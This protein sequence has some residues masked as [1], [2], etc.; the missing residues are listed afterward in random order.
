MTTKITQTYRIKNPTWK[1]TVDGFGRKKIECYSGEKLVGKI[2]YHPENIS[3]PW[4]V[5][6]PGPNEWENFF[7]STEEEAKEFV[8]ERHQL[9]KIS[10]FTK[11][12][13]TGIPENIYDDTDF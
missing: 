7:F 8:T 9:K 4:K 13:Y 10:P 11:K 6:V 5:F 12:L 1:E 3:K 2:S